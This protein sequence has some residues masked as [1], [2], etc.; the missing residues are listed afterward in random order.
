[1]LVPT[2]LLPVAAD[3]AWVVSTEEEPFPVLSWD[4]VCISLSLCIISS[5][6]VHAMPSVLLTPLFLAGGKYVLY[7][8]ILCFVPHNS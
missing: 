3:S 8:F 6:S 4:G 1:M 2:A 7:L 5:S